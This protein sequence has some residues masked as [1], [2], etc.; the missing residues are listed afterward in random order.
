LAEG[1][2]GELRIISAQVE[3]RPGVLFKVTSLIRRRGFNIET[4]TVGGTEKEHISRITITMKCDVRVV[5]QLIKQLS[6]IPD[7]MKISELTPAES[8]Y[9][10]LAVVKVS[11]QE[12]SKR[13]DLLNYI[14]IFRAKVIDASKDA[15][16][17]EIVGQ[18]KKVSA[19]LD[20]M[21]SFGIVELAK[22]GIVALTR[23]GKSAAD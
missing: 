7:V 10:E 1:I 2:E 18:P 14:Q 6:K 23:G 5:E 16:I 12:P 15:L 4:I 9:R 21:K 3:D 8:V 13:S 17:I 20:L 11:A 19:F 22:T